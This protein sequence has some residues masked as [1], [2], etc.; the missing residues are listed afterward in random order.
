MHQNLLFNRKYRVIIIVIVIVCITICTSFLRNKHDAN[1]VNAIQNNDIEAVQTL[2][3]HHANPNAWRGDFIGDLFNRGNG[4][5]T[6]LMLAANNGSEVLVRD[7]LKSGANVNSRYYN[8]SIQTTPL[9][10]GIVSGNSKVVQLLVDGGSTV[11]F[12]DG[13]SFGSLHYAISSNN[14]DIVKILVD[15]G[16]D[17]EMKNMNGETPIFDAIRFENIKSIKLLIDK[18]ANLN[19]KNK[20]GQTPLS[21]VIPATHKEIFELL[22]HSGAKI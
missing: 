21:L 1:L 20:L 8:G 16:A 15:H 5:F 10:Y 17:I 14:Y 22:T 13:S 9:L 12:Y 7:L 11:N 18:K 19:V 3:A 6:T 4:H 2:L